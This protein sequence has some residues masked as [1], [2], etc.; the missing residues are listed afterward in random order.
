NHIKQ[1]G[2][3]DRPGSTAGV[4]AGPSSG[5]F[6]SASPN[7]SQSGQIVSPLAIQPPAPLT[8]AGGALQRAMATPAA[9]APRVPGARAQTAAPSAVSKPTTGSMNALPSVGTDRPR[10]GGAPTAPPARSPSRPQPGN[11]MPGAP[12]A[13]FGSGP[14]TSSG[15]TSPAAA[16]SP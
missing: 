14:I 7:A 16:R 4:G 11:Q 13:T 8:G 15:S 1:G 9:A 3:T 6:A 5:M 2:K 10:T 12:R